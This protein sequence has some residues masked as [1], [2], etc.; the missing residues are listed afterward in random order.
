EAQRPGCARKAAGGPAAGPRTGQAPPHGQGGPPVTP[1][2]ASLPDSTSNPPHAHREPVPVAG[3]IDPAAP[4]PAPPEGELPP[5]L[6]SG[7]DAWAILRALRRR[8]VAAVCLGGT[9]ASIAAAT[10]W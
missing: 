9:L 8:W 3:R 5:G 4:P 7:P 10:A 2:D 6:S 1:Q